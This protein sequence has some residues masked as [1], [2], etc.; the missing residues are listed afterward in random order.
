VIGLFGAR[1]EQFARRALYFSTFEDMLFQM[2]GLNI[3]NLFGEGNE[4]LGQLATFHKETFKY[5]ALRLLGSSN[6]LG[7][8]S[9][10]VSNMGTGVTDFFVKP[11]QGMKDGSVLQ[12]A[13]GFAQGSKSLLTNT[14]MAPVG[15]VSRIGNSI[16]KGTLAL[17]FDDQFI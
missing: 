12:A 3:S 14:L 6:L 9:R 1:D 13:D 16:S 10:Y 11:Y 8:P 4:V 5:N 17:S 15:A 2:N 7:N